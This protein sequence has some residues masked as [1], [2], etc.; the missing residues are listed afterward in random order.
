MV[1]EKNVLKEMEK[2]KKLSLG[3]LPLANKLQEV[4]KENGVQDLASI[5]LSTDGYMTFSTHETEWEMVRT[6]N[7]N[8]VR[9]RYEFSQ[10]IEIAEGEKEVAR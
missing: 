7:D 3:V 9:I 6:R 10:E 2:F 4:L 5:T 1:D 8:A